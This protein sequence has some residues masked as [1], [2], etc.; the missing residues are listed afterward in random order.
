MKN[1][2]L[3]YL[4]LNISLLYIVAAILTEVRP[5]RT[6]LK[7]RVR[8]VPYQVRLGLIFGMLTISGPYTGMNF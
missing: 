8:S 2:L 5:L 6:I 7:R 3:I 4:L 1:S